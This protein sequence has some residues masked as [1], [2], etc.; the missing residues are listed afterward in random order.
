M[1]RICRN[2]LAAVVAF[3]GL[4][5][6]ADYTPDGH[7][8]EDPS[9]LSFGTLP[10]R[11]AFGS[12]P[13]VESARQVLSELSPRTVSLD[14]GPIGTATGSSCASMGSSRSSTSG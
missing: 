13:D 2:V 4:M 11:A 7:E 9:R 1:S 14:S 10:P 5:V 3:V 8:W 12:F 6:R